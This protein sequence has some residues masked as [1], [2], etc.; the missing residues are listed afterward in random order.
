[1]A[2][3]LLPTQRDNDSPFQGLKEQPLVPLVRAIQP[4]LAIV[5]DIKQMIVVIQQKCT[6]LV[7]ALSNQLNLIQLREIQAEPPLIEIPSV[8]FIDRSVIE[9]SNQSSSKHRLEYFIDQY[10]LHAKI[11]LIEQR[12]VDDEVPIIVKHAIIKK[13]CKGLLLSKNLI[14]AS[15]LSSLVTELKENK[16]LEFLSLSHNHL[17]DRGAKSLANILSVDTCHLSILSLH[18]TRLTDE[19]VQSLCDM[20][21][22]NTSLTWLHI[23]QNK[24]SD[25]GVKQLT[26]TLTNHNNVLEA[27]DLSKNKL[28]T[29]S[30]IDYIDKMF[31]ENNTLNTLWINHCDLSSKGKNRLE[32]VVNSYKHYFVLTV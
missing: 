29:D 21:K 2:S 9:S 13:Q 26:N 4:L 1:M 18:G 14:T 17:G 31:K 22:K 27:L 5:P 11:H 7:D 3:N 32:H 15:G 23:G 24:I 6:E 8:T 28:I 16:T 12:I 19:G 20:L 10:S 30:S 25:Q